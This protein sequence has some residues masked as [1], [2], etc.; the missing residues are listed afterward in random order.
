MKLLSKGVKKEG[1]D[2]SDF[3]MEHN[4]HSGSKEHNCGN[5]VHG[6]TSG[7]EAPNFNC[8]KAYEEVGA[9]YPI[10]NCYIDEKY[11]G[12]V[13]DLYEDVSSIVEPEI[14]WLEANL[15]MIEMLADEYGITSDEAK[16]RLESQGYDLSKEMYSQ[17]VAM[18]MIVNL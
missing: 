5:C 17:A 4:L 10:G 2:V 7:M 14:D 6:Y 16:R 8:R 11:T 9:D 1:T 18:G 13:C 3:K 15:E 12:T